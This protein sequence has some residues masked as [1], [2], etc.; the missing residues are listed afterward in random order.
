MPAGQ[1]IAVHVVAPLE[2]EKPAHGINETLYSI[3]MDLME[4]DM[5]CVKHLNHTKWF[6]YDT[7]EGLSV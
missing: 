3:G 6:R 1:G 5:P 7:L 4:K 2:D